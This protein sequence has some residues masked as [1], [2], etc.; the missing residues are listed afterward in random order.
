MRIERLSIDYPGGLELVFGR[1]P[2]EARQRRVAHV[3]EDVAA[4]QSF[5]LW[6]G[7]REQLVAAALVQLQ[8]AHTAHVCPARSVAEEDEHTAREVFEAM[9]ASLSG[10][11]TFAQ[12]SLDVN[13]VDAAEMLVGQRFRLLAT[14]RCMLRLLPRI[15]AEEVDE[16][17]EW[18]DYDT[19]GHDRFCQV[20]QATYAGSL[21]CPELESLRD[22][23]DVLSGYRAAAPFD[24]GLWWIV[25]HEQRDVGCLLLT[26]QSAEQC[27]L[28]YMGLT[29]E[30]RGHGLGRRLVQRAQTLAHRQGC[31][32]LV[33]AVDAANWPA[34]A[35][36]D[37][38]GF[39]TWD[40]RQ[41][42]ARSFHEV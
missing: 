6:G 41:V 4:G 38:A 24:P 21:D 13:D 39:I 26:R 17:L 33:L 40:E 15:G 10:R 9:I 25:R 18:I 22:V 36:Y 27:E 23:D 34:V 29:H 30:A 35:L 12:A 32:R 16:K 19:A 14:V 2:P 3:L 11:I 8:T 1:L 5:E 31:K 42:Y 28:T 37:E 20:A 7:R